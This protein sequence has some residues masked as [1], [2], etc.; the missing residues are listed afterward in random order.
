MQLESISIGGRCE[1]DNIL[2]VFDASTFTKT[3]GARDTDLGDVFMRVFI[4]HDHSF[5]CPFVIQKLIQD[6]F[7]QKNFGSPHLV[8]RRITILYLYRNYVRATLV[9]T[10]DRLR[11]L[12]S[13]LLPIAQ[14]LNSGRKAG[15]L[16]RPPFPSTTL[17]IIMYFSVTT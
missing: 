4:L 7:L 8:M 3:R 17:E 9:M 14:F 5:V 2:G 10:R 1:N 15:C 13:I 11:D 16:G 12:L 6:G